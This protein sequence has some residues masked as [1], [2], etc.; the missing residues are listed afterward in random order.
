MGIIYPL[1]FHYLIMLS[2]QYIIYLCGLFYF[3]LNWY[4]QFRIFKVI[5]IIMTL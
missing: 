3:V 5:V 4:S 2:T 1:W